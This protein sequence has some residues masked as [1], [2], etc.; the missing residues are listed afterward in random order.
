MDKEFLIGPA[1]H[2]EH[3]LKDYAYENSTGHLD[4]TVPI[5]SEESLWFRM[6]PQD[7]SGGYYAVISNLKVT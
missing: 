5:D 6:A 7:E 2:T 1:L 4:I 3:K